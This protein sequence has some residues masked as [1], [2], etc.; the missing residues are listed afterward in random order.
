MSFFNF[1]GKYLVCLTLNIKCVDVTMAL[2]VHRSQHIAIL[3]ASTKKPMR[4]FVYVVHDLACELIYVGSTSNAA[5]RWAATKSAIK[6]KETNTGLY[7]HHLTCPAYQKSGEFSHLTWTLVDHIDTSE[8]KLEEVG[9]TGGAKCRCSECQRLKDQED[10]WICRLG[11]FEQPA[12]LNA[13]DEIQT[14]VRVNFRDR[15]A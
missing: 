5:K 10:K 3:P 2:K 9:H 11:S 1:F 7:N 6:R 15:A 13:R 4:W 14:R 12:G 8:E